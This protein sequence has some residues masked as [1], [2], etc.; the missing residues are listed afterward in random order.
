[1]KN[2]FS[3]LV[4]LASAAA[5]QGAEPFVISSAV[6]YRTI[7]GVG[8]WCDCNVKTF[9][10]AKAHVE[11]ALE[12]GTQKG[13]HTWRDYK[14]YRDGVLFSHVSQPRGKWPPFPIHKACRFDDAKL[15]PPPPAK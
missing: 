10:Q 6:D 9:E 12:C 1:V 15:P 8:N 13:E 11:V 7:D 3:A 14:A 2:V 4:I 5:Q